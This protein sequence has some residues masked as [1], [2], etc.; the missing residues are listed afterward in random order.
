MGSDN[1]VSLDA[2]QQNY[3][4]TMIFTLCDIVGIL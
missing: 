2:M 1:G 3:L 4:C